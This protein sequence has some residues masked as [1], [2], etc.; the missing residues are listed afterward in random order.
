[1]TVSNSAPA[2][3]V[4]AVAVVAVAQLAAAVAV[5]AGRATNKPE[6]AAQR[7]VALAARVA[8][9]DVRVGVR[10]AGH[11]PRLRAELNERGDR[12]TL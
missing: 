4:V 12:R 3:L 5:P 9:A 10:V 6:T 1:L 11:G 8:A 7:K 2:T